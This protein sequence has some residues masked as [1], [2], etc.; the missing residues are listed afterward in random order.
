MV[1]RNPLH[2][3]IQSLHLKR[4]SNQHLGHSYA[5]DRFPSGY[6]LFG[7]TR[8]NTTHVSH[9]Q[10]DFASSLL[11]K[12]QTDTYLYGHPSGYGFKST[13]EFFEHFVKLM[14]VGGSLQH[15]ECKG[16]NH[17]GYNRAFMRGAQRISATPSIRKKPTPKNATLP[18]EQPD[19]GNQ[20]RKTSK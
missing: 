15:C 14:D 12:A 4:V 13:N 11:S 17:K 9:K 1:N 2:L 5:I 16:C 6:K 20:S 19:S 18:T 8:E 3:F 7:R 10:F